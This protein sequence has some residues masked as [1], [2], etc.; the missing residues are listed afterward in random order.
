[1]AR[2]HILLVDDEPSLVRLLEKFLAQ[3]G[4]EVDACSGSAEALEKFTAA[5]ER[6][7][8]L[9]ADVNMS[10]VSGDQLA[11]RIA[12]LSDSVRILLTSGLPFSTERFPKNIR[13]RSTFLQKPFL[14]RM[15]IEEIDRLLP[16]HD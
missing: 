3:R 1:V 6:Y 4:F 15:I 13:E 10:G 5:P 11:L 12:G 2:A 16:G 7:G 8:L 14:P 9:I